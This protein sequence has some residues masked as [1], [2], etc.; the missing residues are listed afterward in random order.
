MD[1]CTYLKKKI[2]GLKHGVLILT[3]NSYRNRGNVPGEVRLRK[4]SRSQHD[5]LHGLITNISEEPVSIQESTPNIP[6]NSQAEDRLPKHQVLNDTLQNSVNKHDD[7]FNSLPNNRK[8]QQLK[9]YVAGDEFYSL[10]VVAFP[11]SSISPVKYSL[12]NNSKKDKQNSCDKS[13]SQKRHNLCHTVL[14]SN[15]ITSKS[16][17][18]SNENQTS[19]T[20]LGHSSDCK[21]SSTRAFDKDKSIDNG[22]K[23]SSLPISCESMSLFDGVTVK[24]QYIVEEE[25]DSPVIESKDSRNQR[26]NNSQDTF[27]EK[28]EANTEEAFKATHLCKEDKDDITQKIKPM[29][30]ET[31]DKYISNSSQI[32]SESNSTLSYLHDIS[33]RK[34]TCDLTI[35]LRQPL[36]ANYREQKT[37]G[38]CSPVIAASLPNTTSINSNIS[39][40]NGKGVLDEKNK[41][42]NCEVHTKNSF[43]QS[44]TAKNGAYIIRYE[45][46]KHPLEN[47]KGS[48]N[49]EHKRIQRLIIFVYWKI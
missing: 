2:L 10:A 42:N 22:S 3:I 26:T 40:H 4:R 31:N 6:P 17:T 39:F 41:Q 21:N 7:K 11:L 18:S 29:S 44:K 20:V 8:K 27:H 35:P 12:S 9:E 36:S 5:T 32:K 23:N 33:L 16:A 24:I 25:N 13:H 43:N 1:K 47:I 15:E 14:D 45:A 48:G 37:R 38:M 19:T 49:T 46:K 30:K 34:P 28:D